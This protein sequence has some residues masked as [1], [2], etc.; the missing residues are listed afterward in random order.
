MEKTDWVVVVDAGPL[1]HLDEL[2]CLD[3]LVHFHGVFVTRTVQEEFGKHRP[4][5]LDEVLINLTIR[6]D[7]IPDASLLSIA[8]LFTLHQGEIS[9]LALMSQVPDALFL[10]DDTAARLA[11]RQVGYQVH[12]S[13]GLLLRAVR[14][15]RRT[16]GEV[17][18]LLHAIPTQST[19]H[20]KQGLLEE[21]ISEVELY[22]TR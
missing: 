20:I 4:T 7:P 17:I 9:A 2:G 11:A 8:Q 18:E 16:P 6:P 14:T 22:K 3:L 19:L 13:L 1:I 10:T 15:G 21:I 5:D 12:G